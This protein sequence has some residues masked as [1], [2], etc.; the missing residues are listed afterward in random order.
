M[1]DP[2]REFVGLLATALGVLA[3][4]LVLAVVLQVSVGVA[5]TLPAA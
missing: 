5:L 3:A 4:G 2:V 1:T